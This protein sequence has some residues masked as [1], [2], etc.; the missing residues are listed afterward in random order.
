MEKALGSL[1]GFG[2]IG[3]HS[4]GCHE[5]REVVKARFYQGLVELEKRLCRVKRIESVGND[6]LEYTGSGGVV[7]ATMCK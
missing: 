3:K 4:M 5:L 2:T 6:Y 7:K 1:K